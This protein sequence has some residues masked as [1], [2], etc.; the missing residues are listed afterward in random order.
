MA[1]EVKLNLPDQIL[2]DGTSEQQ[3]EYMRKAMGLKPGQAFSD[4]E[5]PDEDENDET[6]CR[7]G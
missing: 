1:K 5:I 2:L 7:F 4:L 6:T 3:M